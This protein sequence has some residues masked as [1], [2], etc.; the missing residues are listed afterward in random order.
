M[1]EQVRTDVG[2]P[3]ERDARQDGRASM[4]GELQCQRVRGQRIG[5]DRHDDVQV[6]RLHDREPREQRGRD[7]ALERGVGMVDEIHAER[8]ETGSRNERH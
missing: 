8:D 2:R 5:E 7:R 3:S 4:P 1:A 6:L